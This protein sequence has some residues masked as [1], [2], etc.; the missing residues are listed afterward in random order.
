MRQQAGLLEH[1]DRHRA[2]VG[3]GVV[4]AV[5]VEPFPRLVPPVLRTVAEREQ[6]LLAAERRSLGRDLD[7]LVRRQVRAL[8]PAGDRGERAVAAAVPAQPGQRDEDLAGVGDDPGPARALQPGV[9][10]PRGVAEEL[11][12]LIA[13]GMQERGGLARVQGLAVPGPG[14][15]AAQRAVGGPGL[16]SGSRRLLRRTGGG[17]G[18]THGL[19]TKPDGSGL[20]ARPGQAGQ[21]TGSPR[22]RWPPGGPAPVTKVPLG[23]PERAHWYFRGLCDAVRAGGLLTLASSVSLAAPVTAA[24]VRG[25]GTASHGHVG[26]PEADEHCMTG[27]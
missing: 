12:E 7:D 25:H 21:A 22:I 18:D 20:L 16:G 8:Q 4:V 6:R 14:Q 3:Q 17:P 26:R 24:G 5:R 23:T 10:G 9:P 27:F 2:D 19:Q 15:R 13:P 11:G 1:P